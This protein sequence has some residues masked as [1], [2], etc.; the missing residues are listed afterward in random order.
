MNLR[1]LAL[2]ALLWGVNLATTAQSLT[3]AAPKPAAKPKLV[4]NIVVGQMRYDYILRF[5]ENFTHRGFN[6]M[7]TQGVS[8]DRA[9]YNYL[10][11]STPSGLATMATGANPSI[12]GVIG[13]HWFN[14]ATSEQ[15]ELLRDRKTLELESS[16][17]KLREQNAVAVTQR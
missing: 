2:V 1:N 8:C 4:V 11:T 16:Q 12:H 13:T 6:R 10:P 17:R 15:V 7:I 3:P 14:Y 9:M 5:G